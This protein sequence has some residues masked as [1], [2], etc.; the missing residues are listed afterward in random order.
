MGNRAWLLAA[1][2]VLASSL[3]AEE[4]PA[5]LLPKISLPDEK[6][7]SLEA[8]GRVRLFT[9]RYDWRILYKAPDRYAL[10]LWGRPD[11]VPIAC[12]AGGRLL[13]YDPVRATIWIG[14]AACRRAQLGMDKDNLVFRISYSYASNTDY[15]KLDFPSIANYCSAETKR[16]DKDGGR[17][18][19]TGKSEAGEIY[20]AMLDPKAET[21]LVSFTVHGG[22]AEHPMFRIDELKLN[23]EIADSAFLFPDIKKLKKQFK[24]K[25]KRLS[26]NLRA[27]RARYD[28]VIDIRSGINFE[29]LR[30]Q[31]QERQRM[32]GTVW[33]TAK[34]SDDEFARKLKR[35][36]PHPNAQPE[37]D[38]VKKEEVLEEPE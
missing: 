16:I 21:P 6:I 8:T 14:A 9:H 27:A 33:A 31:V 2:L 11:K 35:F 23:G 1:G 28:Q 13:V 4:D 5:A 10:F 20:E 29:R 3:R 25:V 36:L 32:D 18:L 38:P 26:E 24:G 12:F 30:K 19:L 22:D 37:P 17:I 7:T 34:A 15:V